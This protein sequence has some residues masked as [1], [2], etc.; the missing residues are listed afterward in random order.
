M[1]QLAALQLEGQHSRGAKHLHDYTSLANMDA[2]RK[3]CACS[4]SERSLGWNT[5][6]APCTSHP[7]NFDVL[8]VHA[9]LPIIKGCFEVTASTHAEVSGRHKNL[10][11]ITYVGP[12]FVPTIPAALLPHQLSTVQDAIISQHLCQGPLHVFELSV[13]RQGNGDLA[14][15]ER[16]THAH[17]DVAGGV[18]TV[19]CLGAVA[20]SYRHRL[21]GLLVATRLWHVAHQLQVGRVLDSVGL[22]SIEPGQGTSAIP[23]NPLHGAQVQLPVREA[24][25]HDIASAEARLPRGECS[26]HAR[27]WCARCVQA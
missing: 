6:G 7:M 19:S 10:I 27:A 9:H 22:V 25:L 4:R 20:L 13:P 1:D 2:R 11:H 17:L 18:V 8:V 23:V 26:R 16:V 24:S 3:F 21:R 14:L 5:S 12:I 15:Q